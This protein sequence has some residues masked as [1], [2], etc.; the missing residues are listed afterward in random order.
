MAVYANQEH[1]TYAQMPQILRSFGL[2]AV[3]NRTQWAPYGYESG[4]DAAVAEWIGVDGSKIFVI[5]RYNSMEYTKA[6]AANPK[7]QNGSI[8]GHNRFWRTKE[9]FLQMRD[10]AMA[11]GI[12]KPLMTM[13]EDI[14]PPNGDPRTRRWIS[15]P[16]CPSS[17]LSAFP[18]IWQCL[19][20]SV[21]GQWKP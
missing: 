15:T 18:A 21:A 3:V 19:E 6:I 20:C 8:T 4:L 11:R 10:E 17:S 1:G 2:K 9:R 5:P 7:M 12:D 14:G 13:L 16:P